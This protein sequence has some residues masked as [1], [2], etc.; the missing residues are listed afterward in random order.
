MENSPHEITDDQIVSVAAGSHIVTQ[1]TERS[2]KMYAVFESELRSLS[3]FNAITAIFG[4]A[5]TGLF[6]FMFGVLANIATDGVQHPDTAHAIC[7]VCGIVGVLCY[8]IAGLAIRWRS[9][10]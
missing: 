4:S 7:W 1:H 3:M 6:S 8:G 2:M 10:E 5:G 9:S